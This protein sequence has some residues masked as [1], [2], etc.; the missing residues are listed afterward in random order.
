MALY[1][2]QIDIDLVVIGRNDLV[3]LGAGIKNHLPQR[4]IKILAQFKAIVA[5]LGQGYRQPLKG[6]YVAH[7]APR[8][9]RLTVEDR[10]AGPSTMSV[11]S[12][13]TLARQD[14][15]SAYLNIIHITNTIIPMTNM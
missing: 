9:Q 13:A 10:R 3:E 1:G 2:S 12:G 5:I 11:R 4:A 7:V 8:W 6:I 15:H 14:H